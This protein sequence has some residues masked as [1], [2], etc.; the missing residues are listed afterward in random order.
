MWT[1]IFIYFDSK[2]MH[3]SKLFH[4]LWSTFFVMIYFISERTDSRK[5]RCMISYV[6]LFVFLCPDNFH[7]SLETQLYCSSQFV[8]IEYLLVGI[9]S[10]HLCSR[11]PVSMFGH[12]IYIAIFG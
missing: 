11:L 2:Y 4:N 3:L 10:L 8:I 9:Y 12:M 1:I 5:T 6:G 7:P